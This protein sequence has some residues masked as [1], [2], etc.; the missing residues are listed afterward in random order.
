[1]ADIAIDNFNDIAIVN[2]DLRIVTGP[3]AIAQ[4]LRIRLRF[5]LGEWFLDTRIGI[6]YY[7]AI[8]LKNPNLV[9]TR[10]IFGQVIRTS[11][12]VIS[13][14]DLTLDLN[15][16]KRRLVLTFSALLD[17]SDTPVD[18]SEELIL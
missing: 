18:F 3:D 2:G 1:M 14:G 5:F 12:G 11:P 7:Q 9:A 4:S 15:A 6:P 8:L 10:G 13:V 16:A 17:G